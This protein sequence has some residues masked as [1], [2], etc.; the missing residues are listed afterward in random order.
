M[1]LHPQIQLALK[2]LA[3]A[4]LP[5]IETMAPVQAR[6]VF[7]AMAKARGGTSAPIARAEDR[8]VP[9]P[10]GT[11][12]VRIYWPRGDGPFAAVV[13]FHGGGH[14]L[15]NLDTHDAV[16]RNLCNGSSAVVVSVDY[17]MG[18]EHRFPA[19]VDDAWA[20]YRWAVQSASELGTDAK[21]TAVCGDSAGGNLAAVV[22]IRARDQGDTPIKL[23]ALIY[24]VADY[25]LGGDSYERY[26]TGYGVL[27]KAAM[28]WFRSHY[29]NGAEDA[30]DWRASPIK[31]T[32][33]AGLAPAVIVA[34]ECDVLCDEG[35]RFA[36]ALR[37][38][39]TP[40]DYKL[41]PG[42]IH[43]FFGMAPAIDDAVNAQRYV[44]DALRHALA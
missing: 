21:R 10:G 16:A 9:G 29:L 23:Q 36:D 35:V 26:A 40:V 5:A 39:G 3:D 22:A 24:P 43:G 33:L 31:A 19:A 20:A 14:V 6:E 32:S 28:R 34:A 12:P 38:A 18:P 17:R 30:D 8:S 25:S 44:A 15:G 37:S 42:M 2:A 11:I 41:F 4:K 27:T 7:D 13:Y 1:A